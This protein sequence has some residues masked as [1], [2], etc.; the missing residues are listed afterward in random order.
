MYLSNRNM[1]RAIIKNCGDSLPWALRTYF[2]FA[3]LLILGYMVLEPEKAKAMVTALG[4]N[5]LN[6]RDTYTQRILIQSTRKVKDSEILQSM[7]PNLPRYQ[8]KDHGRLRRF[9]NILFESRRRQ[10]THRGHLT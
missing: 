6:L 10:T 5:L 7:Y 8:S 3:A 4:W 2:L 1:L 9:L